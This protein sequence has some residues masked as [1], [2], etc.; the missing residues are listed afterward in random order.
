MEM[1]TSMVFFFKYLG[2]EHQITIR[3]QILISKMYQTF[4][5]FYLYLIALSISFNSVKTGT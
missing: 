5:W 3:K 1:V 2:Q 4:Y